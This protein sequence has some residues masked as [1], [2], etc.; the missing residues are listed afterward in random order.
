M[1]NLNQD[2][3]E[4]KSANANI[5]DKLEEVQSSIQKQEIQSSR[6]AG[7]LKAAL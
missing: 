4:L 3:G 1:A 6:D 5:Q 2:V 7:Q